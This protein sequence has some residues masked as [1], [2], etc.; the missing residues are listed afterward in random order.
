[1]QTSVYTGERKY[2]GSTW[3]RVTYLALPL[4]VARSL[5]RQAPEDSRNLWHLTILENPIKC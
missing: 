4:A 2:L 1:M 3:S 5:E